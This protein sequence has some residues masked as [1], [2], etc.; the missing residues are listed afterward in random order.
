MNKKVCLFLCLLS[1][2]GTYAQD[3]WSLERCINFGLENNIQIKQAELDSKSAEVNL[4]GTKMSSLPSL[5]A[6]AGLNYSVGRSIDPFT[7]TIIDSDITSQNG[8]LNASLPVFNGFRIRNSTLRDQ[9]SLIATDFSLEDTKNTVTLNVVTF[10]TNILFNL[11]LLEV[12]KLRLLTT[13]TQENRISTQVDLGALAISD[14]LQI[15][16][17]LANDELAVITAENNVELSTL[18]L[19]QALQI[20]VAQE[21]SIDSP[22]LPTPE[23]LVVLESSSVV[24]QYAL[25]NQPIIKASVAN[26]AA[27]RYGVGIAKSNY[28]PSVSLNAGLSTNYSDVAANALGDSFTYLDQLDFNQRKFVGFSLTIPIFNRFQVV[29]SVQQAKINFDRSSYRLTSA[30]NQLQ[31]TIEQAYLDVKTASKAYSALENSLEA[32]ELAY[33][34][35]SQRLDLGAIDIVSFTQIK[36]DYERVKSDLVRAKYDFIFKTKVLDFYQGKPLNF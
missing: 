12:A 9:Q 34:N 14:L 19:K 4:F 10:Y 20:P 2:F 32:A 1:S 30:K 22:Q 26:E 36:N 33:E 24:Y 15:R 11:E 25:K 28:Y 18:S 21:F 8:G 27:A 3:Q 13:K 31:Q 29:N 35:A 7:N 16:Q 17:Q 6:S 23:E 5:N